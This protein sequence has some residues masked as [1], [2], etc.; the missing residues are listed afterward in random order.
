MSEEAT[1]SVSA[2]LCTLNEEQNIERV[3][4]SLQGQPVDEVILVDGGS[5]DRTLELARA[6]FPDISILEHPREGLLRQRLWGV[7]AARGEILLILDAD[8]ELEAG[9]VRSA[10][11]HME[12]RDLDGSQFGFALDRRSFW[13]RRWSE[14][15]IIS[16]PDG[17]PLSM[18]G[19]PALVKAVLF[20]DLHPS[21]AP[22]NVFAEDSFIR[23]RLV[24]QGIHPRYEAG[25]GRTVRQQ[26]LT[27]REILRKSWAY[28]AED[29]GQV[30]RFGL[31]R[32]TLFHLLW[33]YPVVRG[34]RALIQFGPAT[35]ALCVVVGIV[36]AARCFIFPL[37]PRAH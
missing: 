16:S 15:L 3:L 22:E 28:G 2:V 29:A 14:M 9:S 25:P 27:L 31:Y 13:S 4:R 18:I 24:E 23:S 21:A 30:L 36:R 8:D 33:R 37:F 26:P 12:E 34:G 20:D 1:P 6:E 5:T 11:R 19:R 7:R 17:K 35:S 32:E 10:L